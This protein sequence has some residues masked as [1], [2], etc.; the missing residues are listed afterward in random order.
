[1]DQAQSELKTNIFELPKE[2]F[3]LLTFLKPSKHFSTVAAFRARLR[4]MPSSTFATAEEEALHMSMGFLV[5]G[6]EISS[7]KSV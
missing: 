5:G 7:T 1:M 3:P 2:K 4:Y 6:G